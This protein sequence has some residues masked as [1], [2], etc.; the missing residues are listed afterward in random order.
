M[1][2]IKW[3]PTALNQFVLQNKLGRYY[4]TFIYI[5]LKT[6]GFFLRDEN[7]NNHVRKNLSLS[8]GTLDNHIKKLIEVRWIGQHGEYHYLRSLWRLS[9]RVSISKKR[10]EFSILFLEDFNGYLKASF[11]GCLAHSQQ[12]K[13][14]AEAFKRSR[15]KRGRPYQRSKVSAS[16]PVSVIGISKI[17]GISLSTAHRYKMEAKRTGLIKVEISVERFAITKKTL[18]WGWSVDEDNYRYFYKD[19]KVYRRNPDIITPLL[20][21]S[22]KKRNI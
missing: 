19:G 22:S 4:L 14:I 11:I 2:Q 7:F 3:L 13:E 1:S 20:A 9:R 15:T 16:F 8:K 5:K 12:N 18:Y 6:D 21:Y 10:V 17:L